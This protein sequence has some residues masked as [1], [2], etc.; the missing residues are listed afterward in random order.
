MPGAPRLS[1]KRVTDALTWIAASQVPDG[2]GA[3]VATA[4]DL[5]LFAGDVL[6]AIAGGC[7][8][9]DSTGCPAC[10]TCRDRDL[11]GRVLRAVRDLGPG[12]SG[13]SVRDH[14]RADP[15]RVAATLD[16]LRRE[17][18]VA[19]VSAGSVGNG[20]PGRWSLVRQPTLGHA[21]A[22]LR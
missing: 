1:R 3:R 11:H 12:V 22:V 21:P 14:L 2:R 15:T 13:R 4:S 6:A 9:C 5:A 18:L 17:G 19:R 10:E 7:A 20:R 8:W 16:A